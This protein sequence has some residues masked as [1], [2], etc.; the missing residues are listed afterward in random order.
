MYWLHINFLFTL[1][2]IKILYVNI[3]NLYLFI[4][5][6]IILQNYSSMLLI[7]NFS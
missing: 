5:S 2:L 1:I 4:E 7:K 3:I 6:Q